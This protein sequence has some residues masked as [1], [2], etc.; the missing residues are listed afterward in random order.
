MPIQQTNSRLLDFSALREAICVAK[1]GEMTHSY[2]TKRVLLA[3]GLLLALL[4]TAAVSYAVGEQDLI[5]AC[6][7]KS[8][9][10]RIIDPAK[11]RCKRAE[12]LLTW[13]K[14]GPT[15]PSGR[16]ADAGFREM[17]YQL[18]PGNYVACGSLGTPVGGGQSPGLVFIGIRECPEAP[19]FSEDLDLQLDSSKYPTTTTA[20]LDLF[21]RQGPDSHFCIRLYNVTTGTAVE[22]SEVCRTNTSSEPMAGR[23]RSTPFSLDSGI[24]DYRV[25]HRIT[26]ADG[27]QG[28]GTT[29]RSATI[30]GRIYFSW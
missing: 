26:R 11:D 28:D 15:G 10:I 23:I 22:G 5:S 29:A 3:S 14:E 18:L 27:S 17:H 8:G 21:M 4:G 1:R 30:T 16:D 9:G 7:R 6:V 12:N 24:N 25:Q 2:G 20:K 13:N 19:G